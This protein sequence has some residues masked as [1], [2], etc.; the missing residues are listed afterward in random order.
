MLALPR[1]C[2][3]QV[4]TSAKKGV[5][6]RASCF[7]PAVFMKPRPDPSLDPRTSSSE[8]PRFSLRVALWLLDS[9]RLGSMLSVKHFAG[10]LLK[11]P[12][13]QGVVVAQSRLGRML[14][15]DCGNAR[16]R[17][18]GHELLRQ[19]A[20]AGDCDAQYEYGRLCTQAPISEPR[21]AR[22]WLELASAKGSVDAQRLLGQ[23]KRY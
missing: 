17:R 22:H 23:M 5:E 7:A 1:V 2:W 8:P 14:C 9:P 12:A 19:A 20:R 18:M 16:D 15:H 10:R 13:R 21:Q 4:F 11:Q 6:L 3:C